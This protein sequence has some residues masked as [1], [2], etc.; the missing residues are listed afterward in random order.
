MQNEE[1]FQDLLPEGESLAVV[2]IRILGYLN[3]DGRMAYRFRWSGDAQATEVIGLLDM[4]KTEMT[5][6]SL[7]R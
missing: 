1:Y 5:L 7:D 3:P 2:G 6:D 4:I